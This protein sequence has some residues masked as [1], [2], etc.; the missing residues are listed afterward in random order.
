MPLGPAYTPR[1]H[2]A[3]RSVRAQN[4][5]VRLAFCDAGGSALSR[6]AAD[7]FS[8]II[9]FRRHG[10][11]SGQSNAINEG[12]RTIDGDIFG[13]LNADDYLAPGALRR[14]GAIFQERDDIDVVYGQSLILDDDRIIGGLHPAVDD[15]IELLFRH[16]LISQPS[17][18]YRA[19]ALRQTGLLDEN[20]HYTMDWD[21]WARLRKEGA[22]FFHTPEIF[23]SVVWERGTKTS[24]LSSKRMAE[25]RRLVSTYEGPLSV[26]KT[27]IGFTLH[28]LFEYSAAAPSLAKARRLVSGTAAERANLWR[29]ADHAQG[30]AGL[31]LYHYLDRPAA[32]VKLSFGDDVDAIVEIAGMRTELA[33]ACE[34]T[35][36]F[37]FAQ[38]RGHS[39]RVLAANPKTPRIERIEFLE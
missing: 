26:A 15:R 9:A 39:L 27:M 10:P 18:F 2:Y 3:L 8:D 4:A 24:G 23:S 16:N 28:H 11:D 32:G 12:W 37:P 5:D 1:V 38:G 17:C 35:L 30:A 33:G 22:A 7:E 36:R 25:I 29:A 21:L 34:A 20:L 14:V 19:S 31:P 6:A 13:W